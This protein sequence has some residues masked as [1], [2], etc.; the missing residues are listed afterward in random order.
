MLGGIVWAVLAAAS[1]GVDGGGDADLTGLMRLWGPGLPEGGDCSEL[2]RPGTQEWYRCC[3]LVESQAACEQRAASAARPATLER[4]SQ[5][6][7]DECLSPAPRSPQASKGGDLG[8]EGMR[9]LTGRWSIRTQLGGNDCL[10]SAPSPVRV[11]EWQ[12]TSD[13]E[14]LFV[15]ILDDG[16]RLSGRLE[17]GVIDLRGRQGETFVHFR[18]RGTTALLRGVKD[19]WQRQ[20]N[21]SPLKLGVDFGGY[22]GGPVKYSMCSA[23]YCV[24]ATR[25]R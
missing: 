6:W 8:G 4:P 22:G 17:K 15:E 25:L 11:Q 18:L 14:H 7:E 9:Q 1:P 13:Q 10:G 24:E 5:K 2:L 20:E 23:R 21:T 16:G 12:V 19:A 3:E